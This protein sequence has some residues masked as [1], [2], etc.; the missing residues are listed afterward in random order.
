[1]KVGTTKLRQIRLHRW[2]NWL[3]FCFCAMAIVGLPSDSFGVTKEMS[4]V[5]ID[6]LDMHAKASADSRIVKTLSKGETVTVVYELV[7]ME[8][9]WCAIAE[10][11]KS[12]VAGYVP[13]QYLDQKPSAKIYQS[14]GSRTVAAAPTAAREEETAAPAEKATRP[15]SEVKALLYYADWCPYCR[16]ARECLKSLGVNLVEYDVEKDD[17]KREEMMQKGGTGGV[18]FIDIEGIILKG[19]GEESIKRVV[20]KRRG[21]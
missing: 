15:A 7:G 16:K 13:C 6:S 2:M 8:G 3:L 4:T 5:K 11:G 14:S 1:V 10:E 21:L 19:Y 9:T 18:P 20:A 12:S 17:A